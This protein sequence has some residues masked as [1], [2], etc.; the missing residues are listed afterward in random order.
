MWTQDPVSRIHLVTQNRCSLHLSGGDWG[1]PS[2]FSAKKSWT[3]L[4][5]KHHHISGLLEERKKVRDFSLR[6]MNT[7]IARRTRSTHDLSFWSY[8]SICRVC[9]PVQ[10]PLCSVWFAVQWAA[11]LHSHRS[12]VEW[13]PERCLCNS[14]R[15]RHERDCYFLLKEAWK[16]MNNWIPQS[17]IF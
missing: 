5:R 12:V 7:K 15:D 14:A 13:C 11:A 4:A 9:V 3:L 17:V 16:K 6:A 1:Q 8:W 10:Y 2:L